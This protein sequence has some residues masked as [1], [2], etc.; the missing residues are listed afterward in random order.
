MIF[1]ILDG[2]VFR[3]HLQ[4]KAVL[5]ANYYWPT[6]AVLD[7][8]VLSQFITTQLHHRKPASTATCHNNHNN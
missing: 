1:D 2:E 7:Q 6:E 4:I 3:R 8:V 5:T